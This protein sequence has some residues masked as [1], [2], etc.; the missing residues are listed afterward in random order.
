MKSNSVN[1]FVFD[2]ANES[3]LLDGKD[4]G[5]KVT[6]IDI[7]MDSDRKDITVNFADEAAAIK[8]AIVPEKYLHPVYCSC[9]EKLC[10]YSFDCTLYCNKCKKTTTVICGQHHRE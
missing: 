4:I 3:Y 7:H 5:K 8:G 6:S 10:D 2:T 9:G 1:G